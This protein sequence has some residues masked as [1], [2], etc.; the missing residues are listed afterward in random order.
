MSQ[1]T[2]MFSTVATPAEKEDACNQVGLLNIRDIF[3]RTDRNEEIAQSTEERRF[4]EIMQKHT[5]KVEGQ[6]QLP[7]PFHEEAPT[8]RSNLSMTLGRLNSLLKSF[9]KK[10]VLKE[11]YFNFLKQS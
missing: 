3:E 4:I 8:L 6:L 7:L 5:I 9:E 11:D 1:V 2:T 10:P